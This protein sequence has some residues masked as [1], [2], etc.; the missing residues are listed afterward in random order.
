MITASKQRI[1]AV[2][3]LLSVFTN[4]KRLDETL[5]DIPNTETHLA[6]IYNITL[7]VTKHHN[8]LKAYLEKK[9]EK[10]PAPR[11]Q[12][13]L[14]AA[15][16][17]LSY[18]D[19]AKPYAVV[20]DALKM[21]E[22]KYSGYKGLINAVLRR[23]SDNIGVEKKVLES[24]PLYPLWFM[25]ELKNT[26]NSQAESIARGFIDPSPFF[27]FV[28]TRSTSVGEMVLK[29]KEQGVDCEI[30]SYRG[31]NAIKSFDKKVLHT[32]DFNKGLYTV[33]DISSQSAVNELKVL[34]GMSILDIC[35]APG[36]KAIAAAVM[37]DD[38]A[39]I[40]AMDSSSLRLERVYE[41]I[42]RMGV[43]SISVVRDDF[44]SHSFNGKL[45]DRI[46]LDPPC[47]ALGVVRRHPDIPWN[48]N[49]KLVESLCSQQL[50]MLSKALGLLTSGGRLLYSVCTFTQ[51]ET[52]VLINKALKDV[53]GAV[54][55]DSYYTLPNEI[56]MDGMFVAVLE[57]K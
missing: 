27:L 7:G 42:E 36:G 35:S 51:N 15:L 23:F 4:G 2:D 13:I 8:R 55:V 25:N 31:V 14:E 11:V 45:F 53:G 41:N 29:L 56:G 46:I 16:F 28:N 17:E 50:K 39:E 22:N 33:Q 6:Q 38:A 20:S 5:K 30:V 26:F 24:A 40:T 18:N 49:E 3:T 32:Q 44:L 37:S 1:L 19:S 52:T 21:A 9:L 57:K 48:R 47:S 43:N 34:K 10:M 54:L 12:F